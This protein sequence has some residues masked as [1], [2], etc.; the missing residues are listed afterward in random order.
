M[1]IEVGAGAEGHFCILNLI[2]RERPQYMKLKSILFAFVFM[3]CALPASAQAKRKVIID[4]DAR[5][6]ATTDQQSMLVFIQSPEVETLGITIVSGDMWRD[7]EV[8]HT[9]RMLEIVGRT[10]IPVVPGAIFPL[11]NREESMMRWE[12]LYGKVD[13]QGAWNK[14]ATGDSVRGAYHGPYEV[15]A[16]P[17]G[18]PT[19]KP[20]DED[21][22]H[23]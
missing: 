16:L 11:I 12:S 3:C 18:N 19:T 5:G 9:L 1:R 23:V 7:E 4:Q 20:A 21:A 14:K 10:D 17:E 22:A 8:A 15:P 2:S 13:Y 6:P